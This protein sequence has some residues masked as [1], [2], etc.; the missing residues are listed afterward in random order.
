MDNITYL[1]NPRSIAVIGASSIPKR[2]GNIVMKNLLNNEFDGVIMPVTKEHTSVCGILA[3]SSIESLPT[4]PDIAL[5]CTPRSK[6]VET[7][8]QL[9]QVQAKAAVMLSDSQIDRDINTEN[10]TQSCLKI[11]K[12]N[13]IRILGPDSLGIIVPWS[14]FN[15]SL[16]PIDA[17]KGK[18]AFVSQSGAI[19]TTVLDW[20]YDRDI[21]FSTF[22]SLGSSL[23]IQVA[24]LLDFLANDS[25]TEAILIYLDSI[26]DARRFMS[27]A[28]AASRNKR[29]LVL[30]GGRSIEGQQASIAHTGGTST[31]DVIYD[32]AIQRT[33]M[34][35]VN[36]SHELFAAV[37]TLT[38]AIPLRGDRLA[39]VTNGGG[40]AIIAVDTLIGLG[41]NLSVLSQSTL[42]ALGKILTDAWSKSNPID[43]HGDSDYHRYS[44][45]LKVLMDSDCC[46][47][48]LL[49][50]SPSVTADGLQ[51][52]KEV[53]STIKN[54]PRHRKFNFLTNWSGERSAHAARI[55]FTQAGIPTYRTAESAVTAF[56]HLVNYK[57]NQQQLMETP[58]T[59]EAVEKGKLLLA[60]DWIKNNRSTKNVVHLDTHQICPFFELF[61]LEVLPN[62]IAD[63]SS[64]AIHLAEKL[65]YPVA[66]KLRS[67]DIQHK[68]SVQGVMLNLRNSDEVANAVDAILDRAH[69]YDPSA[70]INGVL[71]Q[72]MAKSLD[73]E[74]L[75]I[76]VKTDPVFGPSIFIG[77]GGANWDISADSICGLPPLNTALAKNLIIQAMQ[78]GKIRQYRDQNTID[79]DGLAQILVT[80]SQMIIE[81]PEIVDLDIHPLLT[82]GTRF[83]ILDANLSIAGHQTSP[84]QRLAIRPY[85]KEL[86]ESVT[87]KDGREILIRPI[88]PEDEPYHANFIHNVSREDLYKRFFS[89]VGEFDHEA[90][91]NLTQIDFD[92]EMAFVAVEQTQSSYS[93]LG[94]SRAILASDNISSD[95]AVLIRSDQQGKGLGKLLMKKI[96]KYC[97][98]KQ[99]PQLSGVTM[100]NN[101]GMINMAKEFGFDIDIQF[102]ENI[103]YLNLRL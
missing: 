79:I 35:R 100:P 85:P 3:Y 4:S 32:S 64:E 90:L 94:V 61:G 26:D 44:E 18:L 24:D 5:V 88:L 54:H 49:M 23:D 83:I 1:I 101:S 97:Q 96:I 86:E 84:R 29:I 55:H 95:F 63:D 98:Q 40:P 81:C 16:S 12:E 58:T 20:A 75:R 92:R 76:Q 41:G 6:H 11:A 71:I 7:F 60:K 69:W 2:S 74:E 56:M 42:D 8:K 80:I 38:H 33:G 59:I 13:G 34:L 22:V 62:Y 77:Q 14:N 78:K 65:G 72:K 73:F 53:V 15:A 43:I 9:A 37:E 48:I 68:S 25:H 31:L 102:D 10:I 51:T 89:H 52:A 27:A 47:A 39:I 99:V 57:R 17:H 91:A 46:D 50:C 19:C 21:G 67:V 70:H 87:L 66:V 30:K 93:I 45:V 28:R 36:N 82:K 103:A